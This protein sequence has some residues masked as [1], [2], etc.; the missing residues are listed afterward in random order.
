MSVFDLL[1][2][3]TTIRE[4]PAGATLFAAGDPGDAMY[5]VLDGEVEV[6][7][8]DKPINSH[9]PGEIF[10]EMALIDREV[11]SATVRARTDCRVVTVDQRRFVFLVTQQPYFA[12]EVMGI[13]AD[14]LRLRTQA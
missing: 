7:V 6:L 11:R 5:Y 12:L 14:R 2:H 9:G 1:K 10:G 4:F 3:E 13:L 8:G